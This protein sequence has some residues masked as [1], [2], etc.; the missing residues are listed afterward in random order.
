MARRASLAGSCSAGS[1][2]RSPS[3]RWHLFLKS[4]L[5]NFAQ[6]SNLGFGEQF[7]WCTHPRRP[8]LSPYCWRLTCSLPSSAKAGCGWG[9]GAGAGFVGFGVGALVGSALTAPR[10]VYVIPAAPVYYGPPAWSPAWYTYCAQ[11]YPGFN[12]QTGYFVGPDGQSYFCR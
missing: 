1:S 8:L 3:S 2:H 10:P 11:S 7:L 6:A 12:P 5:A 9:C 4:F